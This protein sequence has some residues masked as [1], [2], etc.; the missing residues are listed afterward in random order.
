MA[1]GAGLVLGL[2]D[3]RLSPKLALAMFAVA[4]VGLL[5]VGHS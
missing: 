1:V 4:Y 5:V 3:V 2:A